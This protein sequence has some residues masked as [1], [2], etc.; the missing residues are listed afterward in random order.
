MGACSWYHWKG[1]MVLFGWLS[2]IWEISVH[3]DGYEPGMV[4]GLN[5]VY[6]LGAQCCLCGDFIRSCPFS[7]GASHR[8]QRLLVLL[9]PIQCTDLPEGSQDS[10]RAG[11]PWP[12]DPS[13]P[14]VGNIDFFALR[15][16]LI[17]NLNEGF[18][19]VSGTGGLRSE[20]TDCQ[21]A[22]LQA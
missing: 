2:L 18:S 22:L 19:P 17:P 16:E 21:G 11:T 8:T 12:L 4:T 7:Q 6:W 9:S 5:V 10:K 3:K 1:P 20:P 15:Y 13:H 14:R